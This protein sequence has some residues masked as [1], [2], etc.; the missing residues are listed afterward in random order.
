MS[1]PPSPPD[2]GL[3]KRPW[4]GVGIGCG[5]VLAVLV[6][7]V[8]CLIVFM[9]GTGGKHIPVAPFAP[10]SAI[11]I[12]HLTD[13]REDPG[14][15]DL[16]RLTAEMQHELPRQSVNSTSVP[17]A[18]L[19]W[20]GFVSQFQG[21]EVDAR[22]IPEAMISL[23]PSSSGSNL[24]FSAVATLTG[25]PR[26]ARSLISVGIWQG[27]TGGA[28]TKYRNVPIMDMDG[29]LHVAYSGGAL[30]GAEELSR[31]RWMID[32]LKD[33]ATTTNKLVS[34]G[35]EW[36]SQWDLYAQFENQGGQLTDSVTSLAVTEDWRRRGHEAEVD[37]PES[38]ESGEGGYATRPAL[39]LMGSVPVST[40][41]NGRVGINVAS[42]S[43]IH[44][45]IEVQCASVEVAMDVH[46]VLRGNIEDAVE[47]LGQESISVSVESRAEGSA[48]VIQ[49]HA[50]EVDIWLE[51]R[52][53]HL[54]KDLE[55]PAAAAETP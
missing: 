33:G 11:V 47:G 52:I 50:E 10:E 1:A 27:A 8:I 40:I 17:P 29:A 5:V 19:Q 3:R 9:L 24:A 48:V 49:V 6:L 21:D 25:L 13:C 43:G 20:S 28:G 26:M 41:V 23:S 36:K 37:E 16:L 46:E 18:L 35:T 22:I 51:Q 42:A 54:L 39:E 44:G 55:A 45:E 30:L 4:V 53:Q 7:A 2:P 32:V 15:K 34:S 31:M 14:V 12:V 38:P